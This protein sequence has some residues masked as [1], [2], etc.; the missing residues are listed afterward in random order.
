MG[1]SA[2]AT[3]CR[4]GIMGYTEEDVVDV[5]VE[6]RLELEER[7][8]S[9]EFYGLMQAYR[10]VPVTNQAEATSC[11]RKVKEFILSSIDQ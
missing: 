7:L 1:G 11:F 3:A 4:G 2:R 9:E 8:D 10:H 5:V 6:V